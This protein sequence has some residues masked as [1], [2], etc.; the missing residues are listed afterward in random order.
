MVPF[1]GRTVKSA[2]RRRALTFQP[3]TL[4]FSPFCPLACLW[5]PDS[6]ELPSYILKGLLRNP[7]VCSFFHAVCSSPYLHLSFNSP[8]LSLSLKKGRYFRL[9]NFCFCHPL[10][11]TNSGESPALPFSHHFAPNGVFFSANILLFYFAGCF[12]LCA[13]LKA[14]FSSNH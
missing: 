11:P 1:S 3:A 12:V 5:L 14:L 10:T 4:L 13:S 7:Q 9:F 6:M 2:D 8:F